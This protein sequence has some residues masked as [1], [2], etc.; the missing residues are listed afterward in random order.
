MVPKETISEVIEA[1]LNPLFICILCHD[2]PLVL[3]IQLVNL[4]L[5]SNIFMNFG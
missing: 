5:Y 2:N 4:V 1:T 3:K